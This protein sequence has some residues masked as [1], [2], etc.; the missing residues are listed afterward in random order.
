[1]FVRKIFLSV[2][3]VCLL[4]ACGGD[5]YTDGSPSE[6]PP[7]DNTSDDVPER[8]APDDDDSTPTTDPDTETDTQPEYEEGTYFEGDRYRA[9]GTNP[10]I[11]VQHDPLSTF[12]ADVDTASYDIFRRDIVYHTLPN[13]S[14]V[15]LEEYVNAFSYSYDAP[16]ADSMVPFGIHTS[17]A[18]N[19][20]GDTTLLAIGIQGI[21]SEQRKPANLI[22]LIDVSGSMSGGDKLPLVQTL[23]IEAID[24]LDPQDSISIVTYAGNVSVRLEPTLVVDRETIEDAIDGLDAGGSTAGADGLTLAYQ[25]AEAGF[26]EDGI[27]HI[28]M[29]TD[30]D[31]NVGPYTD[32]E[33]V[34]LIEEKRETGI[35]LTVLGF[36]RGDLNDAMMEAISN[37]GNGIYAMIAT[38]DQAIEYA[39]T[40][41]VSTM[42]HIAKDVKIQI[43]FNP[44]QVYAYRQLGY[45]NRALEDDDFRDDLVDA[46]EIGSGHTVTALYELVLVGE[47]IPRADNAPEVVDGAMSDEEL[48]PF[49]DEFC[50]VRVRYKE[51]GAS[52]E[53]QAFEVEE[54]FLS[55]D[56][57]TTFDG[58][59]SDFQ[60]AVAIA[61]FA[62]IMKGSPY[63]QMD[64]LDVIG[65]IVDSNVGTDAGRL[66]FQALFDT[67]TSLLM[68][69]DE[70]WFDVYDNEPVSSSDPSSSDPSSSDS[71]ETASSS[72]DSDICA[73][74]GYY[75]DGICDNYCTYPDPD[76]TNRGS[77]TTEES[78]SASWEAGNHDDNQILVQNS[79]C[80]V[81]GNPQGSSLMLALIPVAWFYLTTRRRRHP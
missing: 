17:A 13:P 72:S 22:F 8:E 60:W 33:L 3:V 77:S 16:D 54:H 1:M 57:N 21:E 26:I 59:S 64:A 44:S 32:E 25:Q 24:V 4:G 74:L 65:S 20:I 41:L 80:S 5:E 10:F 40:Q 68:A 49:G 46:G 28:V 19:P 34:S 69:V 2:A 55:S 61:A 66:E 23:L 73:E 48:A 29:C 47:E 53:A 42:V 63:A 39:N 75:N 9:P 56:I 62:E 81:A 37:A 36:G 43:E 31:F 18:P 79:G 27:N 35:T 6:A 14:S 45:E 51:V 38:E 70:D 58:T 15:R 52:E 78:D 71:S 76:C 11:V 67:A 12:A 7:D 50:R 30:G